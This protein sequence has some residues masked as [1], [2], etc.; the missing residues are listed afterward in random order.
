[1]NES[2]LARAEI[3]YSQGRM[4]EA[5]KLLAD[6][7]QTAPNNPHILGMY[8]QVKHRMDKLSEAEEMID[9]AIHA[10]PDMDH[11]FFIK[12]QILVEDRRNQEAEESL[13]QA[14]NLNPSDADYFA[15]W[16]MI[17]I[18]QV[19]FNKALELADQALQLDPSNLFAL[20]MRSKALLKL[21]RKEDSFQ[22]IN[23]ALNEDPNNP[24]THANLGWGMLEKGDHKEALEHFKEA[25]KINPNYEYAQAG[26]AEALKANYLIYRLF[27][28]YAFW[29]SNKASQYQWGII[30]GFYLLTRFLNR[31][32]NE[33]E[34]LRPFLMPIVVL[35]VLA[36]F[37]TWVLSPLIN[38]FL[39]LNPYGRHLLNEKQIMSSTLV[40][41]STL[42]CVLGLL[43]WLVTGSQNWMPVAIF[44]LAMMVPLSVMFK[45][46]RPKN[47]LVLA[48][49]VLFL[50]GSLAIFQTFNTGELFNSFSLPFLMGFIAFQWG[51]NLLMTNS[52]R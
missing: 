6:I 48:T 8:A 24:L 47:I 21:D 25:L 44:G 22:T 30:I 20:N 49:A 10:A 34:A 11:L 40:G 14:I 28:K 12:A 37:S 35:M 36:A 3:L 5:G 27:L 7:L 41:I 1:M 2:L 50:L 16:S 18:N 9:N 52:R 39:R 29:M 38:L 19:E 46:T 23:K 26:M 42:I 45:E 51:A 13:Q 33:V 17:K 15:L 32:A 31:M 4:E 43:L